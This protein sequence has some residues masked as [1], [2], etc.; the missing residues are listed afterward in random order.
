MHN[1]GV[2]TPLVDRS[3]LYLPETAAA[4]SHVL[5]ASDTKRVQYLAFAPKTRSRTPTR[6]LRAAR[7]TCTSCGQQLKHPVP[8]LEPRSPT[9]L[10]SPESV[11]F[12]RRKHY[13]DHQPC[14]R[15]RIQAS[16]RSPADQYPTRLHSLR[17][18]LCRSIAVP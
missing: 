6:R 8:P 4:Q 11:R 1:V 14:L 10:L 12:F 9:R 3:H 18:E 7:S 17:R 16:P 13:C 5:R 15:S 2:D